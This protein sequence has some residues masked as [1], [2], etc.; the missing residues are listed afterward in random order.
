MSPKIVKMQQM[1]A[2]GIC[3]Q[4]GG[5]IVRPNY[6]GDEISLELPGMRVIFGRVRLRT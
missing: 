5:K 4:T 3:G 6:T 1:G 2:V